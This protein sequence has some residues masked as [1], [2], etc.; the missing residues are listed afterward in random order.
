[1]RLA[2][3]LMFAACGFAPTTSTDVLGDA[4]RADA[5]RDGS[6]SGSAMPDALGC[7][8]TRLAHVCLTAV[9]PATYTVSTPTNI[10]TDGGAC[11]QVVPQT[12]GRMLCVIEAQTITISS[13]LS[14]TGMRPLVL[15]ATTT[16]TVTGSGSIDV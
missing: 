3:L 8:G 15:L 1:M 16:L 6:G 9:P 5:P 11:T 2:A 14:A 13:A 10:A 12:N 7:Y 4:A